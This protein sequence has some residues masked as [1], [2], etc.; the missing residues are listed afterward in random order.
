YTCDIERHLEFLVSNLLVDARYQ[1]LVHS[2]AGTST[3]ETDHHT[4]PAQD[5]GDEEATVSRTTAVVP[6]ESVGDTPDEEP[7]R[8][9][10]SPV[11]LSA[12]RT[13]LIHH[14][15]HLRQLAVSV[16]DAGCSFAYIERYE[17]M[18]QALLQNTGDSLY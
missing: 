3:E 12:A 1:C 18:G 16:C 10:S 13:A 6:E 9:T 17:Q 15:A 5:N 2:Q 7:V 4:K 11:D 8:E 14:L